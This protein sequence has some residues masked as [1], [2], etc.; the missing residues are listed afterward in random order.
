MSL[1]KNSSIVFFYI[2]INSVSKDNIIYPPGGKHVAT[3]KN[4]DKTKAAIKK[5]KKINK[6]IAITR[7]RM[8]ERNSLMEGNH[9]GFASF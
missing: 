1:G 5:V 4:K 2:Y 3:G 6:K 8:D 7:R 9:H